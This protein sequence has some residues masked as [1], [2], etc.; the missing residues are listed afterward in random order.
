M[1]PFEE[2]LSELSKVFDLKLHVDHHNACSIRIPDRLT[3]QLQLDP[4]QENLFLFSKLIEIPPGKFREDVLREALK[5]N[6]QADPIV[7]IFGYLHATNQLILYQ[8]YPLP[9]LTGSRLANFFGAFLEFGDI[10]RDA[11]ANGKSTPN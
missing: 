1:T 8:K 3:V 6:G 9:V 7:G 5:A 4:T 10:W 2:L 11:I